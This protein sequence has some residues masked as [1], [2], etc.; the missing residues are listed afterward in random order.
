MNR[1]PPVGAWRPREGS[2]RTPRQSWPVHTQGS[3]GGL[4]RTLS[5]PTTPAVGCP[6]RWSTGP[7]EAAGLV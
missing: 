7:F 1:W 3:D 4:E 6:Q 2:A 5:S